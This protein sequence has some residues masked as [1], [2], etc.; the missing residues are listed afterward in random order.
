MAKHGYDVIAASYDKLTAG[1]SD[2][3]KW[4]GYIDGIARR[5]NVR[6]IVDL[7]CGTGKMTKLL[8][9][10]GYDVVGVDNSEAMLAEARQKCRALF[11]CQDMA[12]LQLARPVD[13]AVC[14]CDG[15]NYIDKQSLVLFFRRVA[16]NLMPDAPFVFDYSTPYKLQHVLADN[17]F[18]VDDDDETLL[19]TNKIA[20]EALCMNITLFTRRKDGAYDRQDERH[21]Q[22][23]L[24]RDYVAECLAEAGFD[25]VEV[26]A[27]YGQT[28]TDESQRLTFYCTGRR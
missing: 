21:K 14:V 16:A 25:T 9:D 13:M 11:V 2:Y 22:W 17:V 26:T 24:P 18:Y 15:V 23:I 28:V 7:A 12:K 6:R 10:G 1:D 27:D 5:H 4:F 3:G 19:W 20:G 8:L